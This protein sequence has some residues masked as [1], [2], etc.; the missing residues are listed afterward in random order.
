MHL[1]FCS[2]FLEVNDRKT[3]DQPFSVE[4]SGV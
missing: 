3:F 1:D 2:Y 4:L